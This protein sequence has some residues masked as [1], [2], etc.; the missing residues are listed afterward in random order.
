[1]LRGPGWGGGEP[2]TSSDFQST[3]IRATCPRLR[4]GQACRTGRGRR[5]PGR[6]GVAG[7]KSRRMVSGRGGARPFTG[8]PRPDRA[9]GKNP[10][11]VIPPYNRPRKTSIADSG[12]RAGRRRRSPPPAPVAVRADED[13]RHDEALVR[14]A[15]LRPPD[16]ALPP[17]RR[18]PPPARDR[19]PGGPRAPVRP[20]TSATRRTAGRQPPPGHH[21]LGQH[22][23]HAD[24]PQRHQLPGP[25]Q[26]RAD[27]A[28]VRVAGDLAAGDH[29]RDHRERA[30]TAPTRSSSSSATTRAARRSGWTSPPRAR[31]SRPWPSTGS[32]P[33]A[34]SSTTPR[35]SS[36]TTTMSA[37]T[38]NANATGPD[39][40]GNTIYEGNGTYGVTIQSENG[41]TS[42]G[43]VLSNDIVSANS[44]NGIILSGTG[45]TK[46]VVSGTI[47]GSDNTGAAVVDDPG[48]APGQRPA[49]RR[50]QRRR[51]QRR[52]VVQHH[53]RDD[54]RRPRRHP[55]QQELRRLHHRRRHEPQRRRG[56]RHRHRHHRPA[57]GSTAPAHSYGNGSSGVAIVFGAAYNVVSGTPTAP[58]VI[59]DNGGRR[60]PDLRQQDLLQPDLRASTSA[61]T[62]DRR[63]RPA[64]RRRRR[65]R[66]L[67]RATD[68]FVGL[69]GSRPQRH[70]GQRGQ[71]RQPHR[72]R[73][74][75]EL[76]REQPHR[77]RRRA[78]SPPW[79]TARM[80]CWSPA[81]PPATSSAT[82]SS[83]DNNVI[84]GNK[85][86]G[87][88]ISDSG[89]NDNTVANDFIGT[90]VAGTAAVPNTDNGLDIVIRRPSTTP[91]AG[92]R[93]PPATSS[94]A[95]STRAS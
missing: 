46:N 8:V 40:N 73:H 69:G 29:R 41:G 31:R 28:P 61:P 81:R 45:T 76:R 36:S 48:N 70:L 65:G 18:P 75:P 59:S 89:T 60:R 3:H 83:G 16:H 21:Q 66:Q 62:S 82:R 10:D 6:D 26:R 38:P 92:R 87:V 13:S 19:V 77:D 93:P 24:Q 67:R 58:E 50:R 94:R 72:L 79:A 17:P 43:D 23:R 14:P 42:T 20:S 27:P 55:G 11:P 49:R 51:H 68:N 57:R 30:T 33:A 2:G 54:G 34:C 9:V 12:Y 85:T 32:T 15:A 53:R 37:S 91:S 5:S 47:I 80:A 39:V 25:L 74:R 52:G 1:M 7:K 84:S 35:T 95:T 71:R 63:E 88:Y 78:A 44:Y 56:R 22:R 90:N 86:W 64:Q 4:R